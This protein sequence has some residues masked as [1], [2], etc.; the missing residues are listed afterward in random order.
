MG[1]L[2]TIISDLALLLV[3]AGITTLL[4]KKINQ[5]LVIGYI[6]AGFLIGPVVSFIPTV[7]DMENIHLWAE[8]GVIFLMFSLGLEFSLHK[9]V[10]VGTTGVI[11]AIVQVA[12]MMILGYFA[13]LAMG[14]STMDSIFLGGMLSMSSTMI[15][16]KAIEDL[17]LKEEKFTKLAIGTLVIEDIVAIFLMVVLST[18]SVSQGV[19]GGEMVMIIGEL[20]VYLVIWLVLGIYLIPSFLKKTESLM[21]DETLLVASLGI[22]FG[23][24]WIADTLG[25]SSALGAFLAG[26]IMAGTVHGEKVEHLV[27]PCKNLFGAI[28]FVS[29]GL[30]VIPAMLVEYFIPILVLI[31]VTIVGKAILLTLG[32]MVTG[33]DLKTSLYGAMSQTQIGEFSFIIATLGISLGVTSDFLYPVIVAVSVITTFTTPYLIHSADSLAVLLR[34][35]VP[36]KWQEKINRYREEKNSVSETQKDPDWKIFLQG[37]GITLLIYGVL[38][39]GL[40][41]IGAQLL[42]PLVQ[43]WLGNSSL[44]LAVTCV[45]IYLVM[46]PF[47]PGI[48][49][50]RN[51]YFTAL[52][53]KSFANHLPLLAL[54]VLRTAIAVYLV[55]RPM[56][57][58][59]LIPGWLLVP[60]ALVAI[61]FIARSDWLIGRYLEME[62]RF[63]ANFNEKKLQELRNEEKGQPHDWLDEQLRVVPYICNAN[64]SAAGKEL[65]KLQWGRA[66]QVHVIK[67]VRGKKHINVPEGEEQVLPG[68]RVYVLGSEKALENFALICHQKNTLMESEDEE[69]SLHQ[70]IEQQTELSEEQQLFAYAVKVKKG[71]DLAG[72]S[73][74]DSGIKTNWSA[75]LIGVEREL[76]PILDVHSN[77]VFNVGDLLWVLG[78]YK[79]GQQ[80]IKKELL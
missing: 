63:L 48:M 34:K 2:A 78:S 4:C 60:I 15:T 55:I 69:V 46:A 7:G 44:A 18:I 8:I 71:S 56:L 50:F 72:S 39:L 67:I 11:S 64:S 21:N 54:M 27:N 25:F 65:K 57:L 23:M 68:D 70:F 13:G 35:I 19:K 30:M 61:F 49:I 20:M 59:L 10:T 45:L 66:L 38:L 5:P 41:E 28:F 3:V 26:S 51:R 31:L 43:N 37:Y 12:G 40:S 53:L 77:F 9:L 75:C 36:N 58:M 32:M 73:L 80:L 47:L 74:R 29:V 6:L 42:L 76:L 24:V 14:W 22:C 62:S 1:S 16:I 79:M 17:G 52:W 33:E